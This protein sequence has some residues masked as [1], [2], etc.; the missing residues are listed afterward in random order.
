M[1]KVPLYIIEEHHEAFLIWNHAVTEKL[2]KP[3]K[4]ILLH[5]DEHSDMGAPVFLT[6]MKSLRKNVKDLHTFTYNEL[7]IENFIVAAVF[8]RIFNKIYWLGHK[9]NGRKPDVEKNVRSLI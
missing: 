4:N 8:K 5:L 9:D 2:I 1:D 3:S 6:S 7:K